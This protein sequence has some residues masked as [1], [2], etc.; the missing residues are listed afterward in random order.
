MR[1]RSLIEGEE[2]NDDEDRDTEGPSAKRARTGG[3]TLDDEE[4]TFA[5]TFSPLGATAGDVDEDGGGG[6]GY[7]REEV[8]AG[9]GG[10][11][12][13][14]GEDGSGEDDAGASGF[15]DNGVCYS[16]FSRKLYQLIFVFLRCLCLVLKMAVPILVLVP[17]HP[18]HLPR[19]SRLPI[20]SRKMISPHALVGWQLLQNL[21]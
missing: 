11:G 19:L 13:G 14:E 10:G 2:R 5:R 12:S 8:D 21:I 16:I 7:G 9:G 20:K 3:V 15:L 4:A 1:N 18:Q 17:P 6:G